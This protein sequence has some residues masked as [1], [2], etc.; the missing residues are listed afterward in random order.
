MKYKFSYLFIMLALLFAFSGILSFGRKAF[1]E[2][3]LNVS[4]KSAI[5]MDANSKQVIYS[6]DQLKHLPI[7]SMCK[8]MTLL[9]CFEEINNGSLSLD[10]IIVVSEN[11]SGMGGSQIFL[12]ANG[13]YKVCDLLKGIIVAS[14]NDACV[15]L[16]ERLYGNESRFVDKMNEKCLQLKMKDTHFVNC[17]GLPQVDQYSCANDVAIMF[18]E[19]IKYDD[20]FEYSRIWMDEIKHPNDRVTQISNTNKLVRYYEGCE[21]GKTGYTKEAGHCL[22]ACAKRD[23]LRLISVVIGAPDSK[24]RFSEVSNMFNYG[25]SNYCVKNILPSDKAIEFNVTIKG[26]KQKSVSV[27]PEK[28]ILIFS[29]KNEKKGVEIDYNINKNLR[30]PIKKGDIVGT[31]SIFE[32]SI[33]IDEVN[34]ISLD[35]VESL[36]YFNNLK[37]CLD[38]WALI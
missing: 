17:T 4:S 5:I 7:A 27:A 33:M 13:E 21:G 28:D 12:E 15:A 38:N 36:N 6:K 35:N 9:V 29:K 3:L 1:A 22:T 37:L 20:Y 26:G 10:D 19:L 23:G 8:I 14:A 11:A 30:A 24:T 2:P 31:V 32:N 18:A 34:L 25:F 16:A